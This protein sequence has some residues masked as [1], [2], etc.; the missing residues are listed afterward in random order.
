MLTFDA[1]TVANLDRRYSTP[2]M[3]EQRKQFRGI[4]APRAGE[5]GLDVGCGAGHLACELGRDVAP[6]GRIAAIDRSADSVNATKARVARE[7]L[8]H[9]VDAEQGD[10]TA[11]PFPD[12]TFDFVVATQVY[13]HVP[14]I[15]LAV[16]EAAR[17]LRAGGRFVVLDSDWDM[18][19]WE[20]ADAGLGRRMMDARRARYAHPNVPR[21]LHRLIRASGLTL[22]D[23]RVFPVLETKYAPDSFGAELVRTSVEEARRQGVPAADVEAWERDLTSRTSDGEWFFCLNR[24][25]FAAQKQN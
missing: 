20:S 18:C 8:Q 6:G 15:E 2:Q 22:R 21:K 5:I 17:V 1:A 12:A 19:V 13:C 23:T 3:V 10:A 4:V 11:L 16:R 9:L 7:A 24:F 25:I 14:D